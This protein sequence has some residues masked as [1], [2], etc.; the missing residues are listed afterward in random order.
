M[1]RYTVL[2][3]VMLNPHYE[4]IAAALIVI[5][6]IVK[7]NKNS[8]GGKKYSLIFGVKVPNT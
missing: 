5:H 3:T 4:A 6:G 2:L 1:L 7:T 8:V